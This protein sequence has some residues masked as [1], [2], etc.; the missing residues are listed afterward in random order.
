MFSR[1]TVLCA[2]VVLAACGGSFEPDDTVSRRSATLIDLDRAVRL[3]DLASVEKAIAQGADVNARL[4][5]GATALMWAIDSQDL[6]I[7]IALLN[8]GADPNLTD[9]DGA[10]A[11]MI[12]CEL[13]GDAIVERLIEAKVNVNQARADGVGPLAVCARHASTATVSQLIASGADVTTIDAA[14][15]TP[16]MWAASGGK[17][18][19]VRALAEA[20]ADVN[21]TSNAG[22]SPLFFAIK[23]HDLETLKTMLALGGD[24]S[25]IGPKNTTAVQLAVYQKNFDAV[26]ILMKE[27]VSLTALDRH[28]Y[29]LLHAASAAGDTGLVKLLIDA[30]SNPNQ[31]TGPSQITYV[32]E[33]NFGV[34]PPDIPPLTPFLLAAENGHAAVM[35]AL[36]DGGADPA[37]VDGDGRNVLHAAAKGGSTEALSLALSLAPDPNMTTDNG[38]TPLHLLLWFA[39]GE[40]KDAEETEAMMRILADAGARTD[41]TNGRGRTAEAAAFEGLASIQS[42]FVD[43]FSSSSPAGLVTA[44]DGETQGKG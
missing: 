38:A 10:T 27:G 13:G 18:G 9:D 42:I 4:T 21:A 24:A 28:G 41:I 37:F 20:G 2:A 40:P 35:H 3:G 17:A 39:S 43:V 8:A 29:S 12:S 32:T 16:L 6:N 31:R 5:Y 25:H 11:L 1:L 36:L 34:P 14:G 22:F 7:T 15:R 30:G 26:R 33:A 44:Q 23:S 19:S